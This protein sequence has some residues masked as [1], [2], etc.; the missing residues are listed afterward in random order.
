MDIINKYSGDTFASRPP[1]LA[2][3]TT[4]AS[5]RDII[6]NKAV[7]VIIDFMAQRK[8]SKYIIRRWTEEEKNVIKAKVANTKFDPRQIKREIGFNPYFK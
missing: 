4:I 2:F 7:K 1:I 6:S 8:Y 5:D 3:Y